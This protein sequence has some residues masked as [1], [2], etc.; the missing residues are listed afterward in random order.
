MR[1]LGLILSLLA[2]LGLGPWA[3]I[4]GHAQVG[5]ANNILCNKVAYASP[6]TIT[7]T[8]LIAAVTGQVIVICGWHVTSSVTT[9]NSFSI[10]RGTQVTNPCDTG[11][12]TLVGALHLINSAPS[13]DHI[14]FASIST[15]VSQQVCVTTTAATALQIVLWYAQF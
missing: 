1:R 6:S 11:A 9:D 10:I 14:E 12:V 5:P 8:S 13:V 4:P 7:T 2:A 3:W 15:P